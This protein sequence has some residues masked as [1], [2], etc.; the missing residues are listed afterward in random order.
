MTDVD[1]DDWL[2][3]VGEAF[4]SF[5]SE[6]PKN[7]PQYKTPIR[8]PRIDYESIT[9]EEFFN[10]YSNTN[11]PIILGNA[12]AHMPMHLTAQ[13][14]ILNHGD[15]IVPLDVNMPSQAINFLVKFQYA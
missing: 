4:Q 13:Y 14:W 15:K 5:D 7:D 11:T 2:G 9:A 12:D 8:V 6:E 1:V 10:R 3:I